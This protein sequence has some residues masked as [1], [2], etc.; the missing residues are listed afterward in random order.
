MVTEKPYRYMATFKGF[1][2]V[3]KQIPL[4]SDWKVPKG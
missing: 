2:K 4:P 3:L 1:G